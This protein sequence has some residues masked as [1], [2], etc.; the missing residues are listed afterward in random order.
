MVHSPA[1]APT[2]RFW[3]PFFLPQPGLSEAGTPALPSPSPAPSTGTGDVR[4]ARSFV[5]SSFTRWVSPAR[6]GML[7]TFHPVMTPV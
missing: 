1:G 4:V 7:L 5:G 6:A 2:N 3:L